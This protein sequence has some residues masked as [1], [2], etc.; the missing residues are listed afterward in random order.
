MCQDGTRA[1]SQGTS[2]RLKRRRR[3]KAQHR[4][5]DEK[6][7]TEQLTMCNTGRQIREHRLSRRARDLIES[8]LVMGT[9]D[10]HPVTRHFLKRGQTQAH[11]LEE[12]TKRRRCTDIYL[13]WVYWP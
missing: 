9:D 8:D 13:F 2:Q 12:E 7:M 1:T 11:E 5:A 10:I 4:Q 3:H 6:P